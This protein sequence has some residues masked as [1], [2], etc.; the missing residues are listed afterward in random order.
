MYEYIKIYGAREHNL[1][2]VSLKIP[3]NKIVATAGPSGSGKSTFGTYYK[4]SV[5]GS[6][7]N[8]WDL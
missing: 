2:N 8:L 7:W 4:E 1:K 5:K 3:K 6:T